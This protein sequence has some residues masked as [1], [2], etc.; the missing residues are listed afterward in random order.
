MA[1]AKYAKVATIGQ[2]W[3]DIQSKRK[4]VCAVFEHYV[5]AG[6][7]KLKMHIMV[8]GKEQKMFERHPRNNRSHDCVE[9]DYMDRL[10]VD[11]QVPT[12]RGQ[13]WAVA[14]HDDLKQ[15]QLDS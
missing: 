4:R 7:Q 13:P 5:L 2:M 10:R 14:T 15:A 12:V 8:E 6:D 3:P 9:E 11:G 1:V